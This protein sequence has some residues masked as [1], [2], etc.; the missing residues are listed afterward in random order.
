MGNG[1]QSTTE[2]F[3]LWMSLVKKRDPT[4]PPPPPPPPPPSDNKAVEGK[5]KEH[6]GLKPAT[7]PMKL[8]APLTNR[9]IVVYCAHGFPNHLGSHPNLLYRRLDTNNLADMFH[10]FPSATYCLDVDGEHNR[11]ITKSDLVSPIHNHA[12]IFF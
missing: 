11:Q 3:D 6:V 12:Y 8:A 2:L 1:Q 4:P 9:T 7:A 5:A 10:L